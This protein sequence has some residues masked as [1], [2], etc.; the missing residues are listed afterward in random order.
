MSRGP[1]PLEVSSRA[2]VE[3]SHLSVSTVILGVGAA[4]LAGLALL[5]HFRWPR[6]LA[7]SF[8][9]VSSGAALWLA[10]QA[11][12]TLTTDPSV[13][14]RLVQLSFAGIVVLPTGYAV[15]AARVAGFS[16]FS[17]WL[18]G[19]VVAF[20][21]ALTL[22]V[23]LTNDW[24]T[25]FFM[26]PESGG[27]LP[28][29]AYWVHVAYSFAAF[30][31]ALAFLGW[32]AV[33]RHGR[34]SWRLALAIFATGLPPLVSVF[35][36]ASPGRL[37]IV[38]PT[39]SAVFVSIVLWYLDIGHLDLL[40]SLPSD[41]GAAFANAPEALLV[42]DGRGRV[43][44]FSN[45]AAELLQVPTDSIRGKEIETLLPDAESALVASGR[46]TA[47]IRVTRGSQSR[48]IGLRVS[49]IAT[50][51]ADGERVL[52]IRDETRT[53]EELAAAQNRYLELFDEHPH[54]QIIFHPVTLRILS[55]NRT[56]VRDYQHSLDELLEMSVDLLWAPDAN[57]K[58]TGWAPPTT[59]IQPA[60]HRRKDG[61]EFDVEVR[62]RIVGVGED[63]VNVL[64]V[65][66]VSGRM[67]AER[68]V[69]RLSAFAST[70]AALWRSTVDSIE[71]PLIVL[72]G[73]DR[74][75]ALNPAAVSALGVE[76][77]TSFGRP[78]KDFGAPGWCPVALEA[79]LESRRL[80]ASVERP[81][82]DASDN[83]SAVIKVSP[84]AEASDVEGARVVILILDTTQVVR[85]E[86][87]AAND[88]A[89]IRLGT[90]V[91][92]VAHDVRGPLAS[93]GMN[94]DAFQA[95]IGGGPQVEAALAPIHRSLGR[96]NA[97]MQALLEYGRPD[98]HFR[99]AAN[100][101]QLARMAVDAR[102][103]DASARDVTLELHGQTDVRGSLDRP[104]VLQ[105]IDNLIGNAVYHSPPGAVVEVQ[106]EGRQEG[107][108]QWLVCRVSDRG[109][110]FKPDELARVFEPFYSRR[111]GGIGLGLAIV[112]RI[113]EQHEGRAWAVNRDGG[114]AA[115]TL[116]LKG[117]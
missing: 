84:V 16:G 86:R 4:L 64:E 112:Q 3:L 50:P 14:Y 69:E 40:A 117:A 71:S 60:I 15:L 42:L 8:S 56:A 2:L 10:C 67:K 95:E 98:G 116:E 104:R 54:A 13:H 102:R 68:Q 17:G 106:V 34:F 79:V 26:H 74:I 43:T 7:P 36:L 83:T 44:D 25:L 78:F 70:T 5:S 57:S 113:A 30:L 110:G 87:R 51:T 55:A 37:A 66:D 90:L 32:A 76:S 91:G 19:L 46:R 65:D 53:E 24:H 96:I 59:S 27:L 81:F 48:L 107:N 115:V 99:S 61:E 47:R 22:V 52:A 114:G 33:R 6:R 94:L 100:L 75:F 39:A 23:V 73:C 77:D 105:A 49:E 82:L 41:R 89:F 92:A 21:P 85:M 12:E 108:T 63:V 109:K 38:D 11:L 111:A 20:G 31:F 9:A 62:I 88:A 93:L 58:T 101:H 72:D 29:R 28:G 80:G 97:L 103:R 18:G 45:R 35:D 1:T